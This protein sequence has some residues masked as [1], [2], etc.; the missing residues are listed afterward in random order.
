[1]HF[2]DDKYYEIDEFDNKIWRNNKG[3]IHRLYKPA[4]EY[5]DGHKEWYINGICHRI[6]GPAVEMVDSCKVWVLN[7]KYYR[8]DGPAYIGA[9]GNWMVNG[10]LID[11]VKEIIKMM[12]SNGYLYNE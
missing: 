8:M 7:G 4:K 1:M 3:K 2:D 11:D 5:P 12:T 10:L 6:D 9:K